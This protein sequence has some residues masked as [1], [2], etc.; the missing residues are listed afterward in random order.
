MIEFTEMEAEKLV[1]PIALVTLSECG[2]SEVLR[3]LLLGLSLFYCQSGSCDWPPS[4][5]RSAWRATDL[6]GDKGRLV[7]RCLFGVTGSRSFR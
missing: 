3:P 2:E 4:E 5:P 1:V 7:R 6:S